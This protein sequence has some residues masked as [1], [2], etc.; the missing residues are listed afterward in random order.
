MNNLAQLG[1]LHGGMA[2]GVLGGYTAPL[3]TV[4]AIGGGILG[5]ELGNTLTRNVSGGRYNTWGDAVEDWTNGYIRADNGQFTNP[6]AWIG[7][8]LGGMGSEILS[9][10]LSKSFLPIKIKDFGRRWIFS[11]RELG[12]YVPYKDS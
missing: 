4:G 8:S 11:N 3:A 1:L 6:G 5:D 7:G 10:S 9:N 12:R 2:L